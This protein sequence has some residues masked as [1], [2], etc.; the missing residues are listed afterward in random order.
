M[1]NISNIVIYFQVEKLFQDV[2]LDMATVQ[3]YLCQN[4]IL[5]L[6]ERCRLYFR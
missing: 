2:Q 3:I 6:A 1:E 5:F 4:E